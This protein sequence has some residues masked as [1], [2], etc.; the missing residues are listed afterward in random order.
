MP[1]LEKRQKGK[2]RFRCLLGGP[3]AFPSGCGRGVGRENWASSGLRLSQRVSKA[4]RRKRGCRLHWLATALGVPFVSPETTDISKPQDVQWFRDASK[5]RE[6]ISWHGQASCE[7]L[8]S[9]QDMLRR[10]NV[11]PGVGGKRNSNAGEPDD[12]QKNYLE[13]TV[14]VL[15]SVLFGMLLC[16]A[17]HL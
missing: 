8:S 15:G 9:A 13:N 7:I 14:A 4:E 3:D 16:C 10:R 1:A 11:P 12:L 6:N 5:G 2:A 17:I